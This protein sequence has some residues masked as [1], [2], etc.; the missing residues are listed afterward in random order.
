MPKRRFTQEEREIL[1]N[2]WHDPKNRDEICRRLGRSN[3]SCSFEYYRML[4]K[5]GITPSEHKEKM[6]SQNT[7]EISPDFKDYLIIVLENLIT[8]IKQKEPVSIQV[9]MED[10]IALK[11]KV[12]SLESKIEELQLTLQKEREMFQNNYKE[13]DHWLNEYFNLT[14]IEKLASLKDFLPKVKTVVDKYGTVI[15][16]IKEGGLYQMQK[17]LVNQ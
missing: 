13:L 15:G 1:L 12:R 2:G 10:N 14:S 5:K 6:L 4:R 17:A 11:E 16:L 8:L 3:G 9:L 7:A